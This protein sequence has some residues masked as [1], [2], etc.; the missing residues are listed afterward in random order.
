MSGATDRLMDW[1]KA[2]HPREQQEVMRYIYSTHGATELQKG[3]Y[4]GPVP[5][6]T[7]GRCPTC[8]K[9]F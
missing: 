9:P 1:L 3:L 4:A 8:G 5:T 7:F 2:L 6:P